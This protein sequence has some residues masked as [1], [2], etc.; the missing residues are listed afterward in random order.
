VHT[1]SHHPGITSI[2]LGSAS[3]TIEVACSRFETSVRDLLGMISRM[4]SSYWLR[5]WLSLALAHSNLLGVAFRGMESSLPQEI[6]RLSDGKTSSSALRWMPP[7][8]AEKFAVDPREE[9]SLKVAK[10]VIINRK[11]SAR[12]RVQQCFVELR[13]DAAPRDSF[14]M[15]ARLS[16]RLPRQEASSGFCGF[17]VMSS[18]PCDLLFLHFTDSQPIIMRDAAPG[19]I[20]KHLRVRL[21]FN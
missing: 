16:K 13:S 1:P 18:R 14:F 17:L 4:I 19:S 5:V 12:N 3:R 9:C 15:L 11:Q 2:S 21:L 7:M 20:G 6:S 10:K 8:E